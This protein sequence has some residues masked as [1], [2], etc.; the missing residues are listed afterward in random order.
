MLLR[1]GLNSTLNGI[2]LNAD[3]DIAGSIVTVTNGLTLNGTVTIEDGSNLTGLVFQG[4]QRFDGTANILLEAIGPSAGLAVASSGATLTLGPDVTVHGAGTVGYSHF[5]PDASDIGLVIEGTVLADV[6]GATLTLA[7]AAI[8]NQGLLGAL[9]GAGLS[10]QQRDTT[11][12]GIVNEGTVSLDAGC[13]LIANAAYTQT[14]GSTSL[15]GATLD[16]PLVDLQGGLLAGSGIITGSVRN[17]A[18]LEGGFGGAPGSLNIQGDYTQAAE[19]TLALKIGGTDPGTGYDYLSIGGTATL[20]GTLE[21][22]VL[23]GFFAQPGDTFTP[24]NFGRLQGEFATID[25]L[26]PTGRR[27]ISTRSTMTPAS[28]WWPWRAGTVA[29]IRANGRNRPIR[30]RP[31]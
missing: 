4:S 3:L 30:V 29:D 5:L 18:M 23:D 24:V 6:P 9:D 20:D 17:A 28:P 27:C 31:R 11:G 21:V 14:A 12:A 8:D 22:S 15:N 25:G 10:L 16:A 19:G 13:T 7:A 2:T 26:H 1:L